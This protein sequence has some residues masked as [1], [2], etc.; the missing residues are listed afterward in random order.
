[1]GSTRTTSCSAP[2]KAEPFRKQIYFVF[3]KTISEPFSFF[4]MAVSGKLSSLARISMTRGEQKPAWHRPIP[5]LVLRFTPSNDFAPSGLWIASI[6]S[7][8][9]IISHRQIILPYAGFSLINVTLSSLVRV[10][11]SRNPFLVSMKFSFY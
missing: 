3:P 4:R 5:A 10:F 7:P 2:K 6:I 1:M 11:G 8:S 9:V